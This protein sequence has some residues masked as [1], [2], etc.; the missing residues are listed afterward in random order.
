[1]SCDGEK[2]PPLLGVG[3][4]HVVHPLWCVF[5]WRVMP[6]GDVLRWGLFWLGDE[7]RW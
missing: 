7:L 1:M 3:G 5:R 6:L 4:V 2:Q